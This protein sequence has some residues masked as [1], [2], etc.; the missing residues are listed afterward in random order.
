MTCLIKKINLKFI[1][2]VITGLGLVLFYYYVNPNKVNFLLK[3][4]LYTTTGIYCPGCGSQRATHALLH[5]NF[6][7]MFK[8]N[9]LYF[10]A[11]IL[12]IYHFGIY[13]INKFFN[14][15]YR[16]ILNYPKVPVIILIIVIIFWV[17]RN[18]PWE[19]FN[20]LAPHM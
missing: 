8:Q 1:I 11:I 4:P 9:L 17:L 14:K 2:L 20:L 5:L 7:E 3:C 10:F 19:P 15:Q 6:I 18:L 12:L 13:L 16:S